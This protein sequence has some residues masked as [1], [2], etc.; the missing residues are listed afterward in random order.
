MKLVQK[1][2]R[3]IKLPELQKIEKKV[4][5]NPYVQYIRRNNRFMLGRLGPIQLGPIRSSDYE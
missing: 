5:V 3:V 1:S 2:S 4:R